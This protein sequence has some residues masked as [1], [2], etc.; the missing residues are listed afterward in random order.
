MKIILPG[1]SGFLGTS[2]ARCLISRGH[3]VIVLTRGGAGV[4]A[5]LGEI[6]Q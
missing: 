4:I 2:L 1:G 3:D 6:I 5:L